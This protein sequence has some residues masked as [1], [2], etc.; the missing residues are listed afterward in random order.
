MDTYQSEVLAKRGPW[1]VDEFNIVRGPKNFHDQDVA[2]GTI[3]E[4]FRTEGY[5]YGIA[6]LDL[7]GS[8]A[9]RSAPS[10]EIACEIALEMCVETFGPTIGYHDGGSALLE[11]W[12]H[13]TFGFSLGLS[14]T[15]RDSDI[16][17][18]ES[19]GF[20]DPS[21]GVISYAREMP[22]E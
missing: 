21:T 5:R 12:I 6:I 10:F 9:K 20:Y 15:V 13:D 2:L 8:V 1:I 19:H 4:N 14:G 11:R 7:W 18:D 3:V 16:P 22:Y 17:G